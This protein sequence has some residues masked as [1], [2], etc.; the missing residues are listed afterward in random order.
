M[1][2]ESEKR[3]RAIR[4]Y[5]FVKGLIE[6]RR[7]DPIRDYRSYEQYVKLD[8]IPPKP[9][10]LSA[11]RGDFDNTD[12]DVWL[13][14]RY[15]RIEAYPK[16]PGIL[17]NWLSPWEL[18]NVGGSVP[19]L[20]AQDGAEEVPDDV[21]VAWKQYIETRWRPWAERNRPLY[22]AK[23]LYEELY[24]MCQKQAREGETYE[25]VAGLGLLSWQPK[26]QVTAICR[27]LV[28]VPLS[29]CLESTRQILTLRL[30][31]DGMKIQLEDDMISLED[32]PRPGVRS[33][34]ENEL[35][36]ING[37]LWQ[38]SDLHNILKE[39]CN[40]LAADAR[41]EPDIA[42]PTTIN[43]R[44]IVTFSPAV[45][46]RKRGSEG[47]LTFTNHIIEALE[48]GASV[49][50]AV[51]K[52]IC[53]EEVGSVDDGIRQG[54]DSD[55]DHEIYCPLPAND[56]QRSIIARLD[57][58]AGVVVQ[59]PPGTGK[60]QTIANL[61]CHL[62]AKGKRVLVTSQTARALQVLHDKIPKP[63]QPLCVQSLSND[64]KGM[65]ALELSVKGIFATHAQWDN[66]GCQSK[67][68]WARQE[69]DSA[70]RKHQEAIADQ[71]NIREAEIRPY[72]CAAG[73]YSGTLTEIAR[74][75]RAEADELGIILDAIPSPGEPPVSSECFATAVSL[76][77]SDAK[78]VD[79]ADEPEPPTPDCLWTPKY[80]HERVGHMI[81]L[82]AQK[83]AHL[84]SDVKRDLADRLAK[85]PGDV[86][87]KAC[88]TMEELAFKLNALRNRWSESW[89]G[90]AMRE[91]FCGRDCKWIELYR[92]TVECIK[93]LKA[94]PEPAIGAHLSGIEGIE[95]R[96]LKRYADVLCEHLAK[97]HGRGFGPALF[98]PAQVRSAF[99]SI[100]TVCVDG[101]P[102]TA[103]E[104]LC[105]LSKW[106]EA[107][108]NLETLD[109]EWSFLEEVP[110]GTIRARIAE[111]EQYAEPLTEL[112]KLAA[113]ATA[114]G[115][116]FGAY[117]IITPQWREPDEM[118]A[119]LRALDLAKVQCQLDE[120]R[121]AYNGN[122][123]N[124]VQLTK[125][126]FDGAEQASLLEA[127]RGRKVDEYRSFY[128][129][130]VDRHGAWERA[131]VAATTLEKVRG[132]APR[133]VEEVERN[134]GDPRWSRL[135]QRWESAWTWAAVQTWLKRVTGPDAE[136]KVCQRVANEQKRINEL[137][138]FLAALR[139]WG[140]C[141]RK[142]RLTEERRQALVSWAQAR[143]RLG[144]GTGKYANQYRRTAQKYIAKCQPAIPAWIMPFYRVAESFDVTQDRFDV[145]IVD[146][147]SQS[148]LDAL[149]LLFIADKIVVVGDDMQTSP[150]LM[151]NVDKVNRLR[152]EYI[153]DIPGKDELCLENSL[154]DLA[155]IR[156]S[157]P[158]RLVEH[159]RCM[160]EI[161]GFS[162]DLCYKG[163]P[164]QPLRQYG[165]GRLEPVVNSVFVRNGY[166]EG[167][168]SKHINKPE[169]EAIA[170][171]VGELARDK[172]YADKT[173]GVISLLGETQ[174]K[175]IERDLMSV[176]DVQAREKHRLVC[177]DADAFQG[178]ER[179]VMFLSLV[180]SPS[181]DEMTRMLTDPRQRDTRRYNVAM[182]R[183]KDQV[184]LFHS[185]REKN[186]KTDDLRCRLLHYCSNPCSAH[187]VAGNVNIDDLRICSRTADRS[188]EKAPSPFDS[189]FEVDVYLRI[190]DQGYKV[191]PQYDVNGYRIDLAV[192]GR[193]TKL[194][195]ECDGDHWHG[196]EQ[197][198]HDSARQRDLERCGWPFFRIRGSEFSFDPDAVM[199]RLWPLLHRHG[200]EVGVAET[201]DEQPVT[202][203]TASAKDGDSEGHVTLPVSVDA[204]P[205]EGDVY[206]EPEV[207]VSSYG[208]ANPGEAD[209]VLSPYRSWHF[210]SLPDPTMHHRDVVI[211][212]LREIIDVE[213][214]V[215]WRRVFD[216]Y[217]N[218][219]ELKGLK[220]AKR[221]W[222]ESA[223]RVGVINGCFIAQDEEGSEEWYDL[224][225]RTSR[226]A[227]TRA[228]QSGGRSL[229]DIPPSEIADLIQR[230]HVSVD[231]EEI[232]FRKVLACYDL[233]RLTLRAESHLRQALQLAK[234]AQT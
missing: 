16:P 47:L 53:V 64:R 101:M 94:I 129:Q 138:A 42:A 199:N 192:I 21:R 43:E 146:E 136:Q 65:E 130:I 100:A 10:A 86:R 184:W 46:L 110:S 109:D 217:R 123:R 12:D 209:A 62:L 97:R 211:A 187:E 180:I 197:W 27:H 178:D 45:I 183:A 20:S 74:Q 233:K 189:W 201:E 7:P 75:V 93:A 164:L 51:V 206:E 56:A 163:V 141:F 17:C 108:I 134:P 168:T 210:R 181:G 140:Y 193:N 89:V 177:G 133:L 115:K 31:A 148:G 161:I 96:V 230:L 215:T 207:Q 126:I 102:A 80:F 28:T 186:L 169:A 176:L 84:S 11:L 224:V 232:L 82:E 204:A 117:A 154:F 9:M 116:T 190:A 6:L 48:G 79:W 49:P 167:S 121:R 61:V 60:S 2:T 200:I 144:K 231:D 227:P 216:Q 37:L 156:F 87:E 234:A 139:A 153:Y 135:A 77:A 85:V 182:S 226:T 66:A 208:C 36:N 175:L 124:L 223:A 90:D 95:V 106:A 162:N 166:V 15:P 222:L 205:V 173:F 98:R 50:P 99:K 114:L 118:N 78:S 158:V 125:G 23:K 165:A 147:A 63:I 1:L 30:P 105:I 58:A 159:F 34:I 196:P 145:A 188:L 132:V 142:D 104:S 170:R 40:E 122:A 54:N 160:P 157:N 19:Q 152:Q 221:K 229:E 150:E 24:L 137:L 112:I 218:G 26:N 107:V 38:G 228:R 81:D 52:Q 57:G 83:R 198:D 113:D 59:G 25:V 172:R 212:A 155:R 194:A 76:L 18:N 67:I 131:Q 120:V 44:P 127:V 55:V 71:R 213:Q 70:R 4:L 202:N 149:V 13:E 39:Y 5:K 111:Y 174:A 220:G 219:L 72:K 14:I 195:V 119:Y 33:Q 73:K 88:A 103:A 171:K 191:I 214:P 22:A 151:I 225:V 3:D 185:V 92:K 32:R 203:G 68:R 179:D 69:L 91:V 41:Y 29:L 128:E 8:D 143:K 35:R